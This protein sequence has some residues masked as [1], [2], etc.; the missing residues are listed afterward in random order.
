MKLFY[1]ELKI[2][3]KMSLFYVAQSLDN[4]LRDL[5]WLFFL[6]GLL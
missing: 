4:L 3:I 2:C 1:G 5:I 6:L